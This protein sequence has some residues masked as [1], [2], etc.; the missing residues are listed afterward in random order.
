MGSDLSLSP[1]SSKDII[2][3]PV[4]GELYSIRHGGGGAPARLICG[5]LGCESSRGNPVVTTLP[6]VMSLK[7]D[8]TGPGEWIRSTFRYAADEVARHRPG[9]ETVLAKLSELIYVETVRRYVEEMPAE[10]TGWL[11]GLR[12]PVVAR[13]LALMHGDIARS[14]SMEEL[15]REAGLSRSALADRFTRLIGMAPMHY[16]TQW[17]LQVAAQKLKDRSLSLAQVAALVGYE[18]EAAFSRAFKKTYASAPGTWRR[19]ND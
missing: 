16:L 3:P 6:A 13:T 7:V 11:A 14:W 9:A 4:G 17:R 5:F 2:R 8:E 12:D 1:V 19:A 10:Q 15:G 18:S